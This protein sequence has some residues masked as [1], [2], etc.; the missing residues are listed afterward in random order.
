MSG[1]R[2]TLLGP[3]CSLVSLIHLAARSVPGS[4][5]SASVT[6]LAT[7][8]ISKVGGS[9]D[10]R[11]L[12]SDA[13]MIQERYVKSG[14]GDAKVECSIQVNEDLGEGEATFEITE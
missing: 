1:V 11:T 3:S 13:E 14:F 5:R 7:I 9:L 6:D 10:E 12:F 8:P 2:L 4:R